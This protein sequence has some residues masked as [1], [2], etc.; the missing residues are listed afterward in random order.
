VLNATFNNISVISWQSELLVEEIGV[1]GENHW[2]V[3][4]YC[5]VEYNSP[6]A[7]FK[8]TTLKWW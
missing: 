4:S 7:R 8:L 3:T 2:L 6:W 1:S 5:Y